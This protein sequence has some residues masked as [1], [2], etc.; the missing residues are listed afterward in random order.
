MTDSNNLGGEA[1]SYSAEKSKILPR[2]SVRTG[3]R[4]F[5]KG[6][7]FEKKKERVTIK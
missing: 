1:E 7:S 2:N 6:V 4:V 5:E 3:R